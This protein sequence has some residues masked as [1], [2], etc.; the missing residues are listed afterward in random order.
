MYL[1]L[2]SFICFLAW[3]ALVK[4]RTENTGRH[5]LVIKASIAN[6]SIVVSEDAVNSSCMKVTANARKQP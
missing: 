1:F 2:S 6:T 5:A 4:K 3:D